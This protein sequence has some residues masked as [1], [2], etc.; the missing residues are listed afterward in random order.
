LGN[1]KLST[2]GTP[3][4]IKHIIHKFG[5]L[6]INCISKE[7]EIEVGYNPEKKSYSS[8]QMDALLMTRFNEEGKIL[9]KM[10]VNRSQSSLRMPSQSS[11][12]LILPADPV[13]LQNGW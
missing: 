5:R 2:L 12:P 10:D 4:G 1:E 9:R 7:S 8:E 6:E 11:R 3:L 13:F